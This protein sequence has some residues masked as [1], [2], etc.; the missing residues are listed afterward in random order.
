MKTLIPILILLASPLMAQVAIYAPQS[1]TIYWDIQLSG[2]TGTVTAGDNL[3]AWSVRDF[4]TGSAALATGTY[5]VGTDALANAGYYY[6]SL[7]LNSSTYTVGKWYAIRSVGTVSGIVGGKSTAL[8]Y[9]MPPQNVSGYPLVDVAKVGGSTASSGTIVNANVT[10][11][12]G[13]T[14]SVAAGSVIFPQGTVGTSVFAAGGTVTANGGTIATALSVGSVTASIN[15]ASN[16]TS[17]T[18]NVGTFNA[19]TFGMGTTTLGYINVGTVAVANRISTGSLTMGGLVNTGSLSS[20]SLNLTGI[21]NTGSIS[22]GSFSTTGTNS[23]GYITGTLSAVTSGGTVT[24]NGGTISSAL[25]VGSVTTS[26]PNSSAD[27]T[28]L[29]RLP[30]VATISSGGTF[31][32][33]GNAIVLPSSLTAADVWGYGTR[34]VNGGNVGSVSNLGVIGGGSVLFPAGTFSGGGMTNTEHDWLKTILDRSGAR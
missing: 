8:V 33:G 5:N 7:S 31:S 16:I 15:G 25:S 2:S 23:L 24:A 6:G 3:P 17:G 9:V 14:A 21:V 34:T 32:I 22:S 11:I 1:S 10:Q 19:G 12:G 29:T 13:A 28:L 26:I 27:T 20:G 18:F 4:S 30:G